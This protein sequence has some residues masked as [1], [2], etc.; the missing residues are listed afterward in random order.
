MEGLHPVRP[1]GWV[2]SS[3]SATSGLLALEGALSALAMRLRWPATPKQ[4]PG[5]TS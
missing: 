2:E 5:A 4:P 3:R 1:S